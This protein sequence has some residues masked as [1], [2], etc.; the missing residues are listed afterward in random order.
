MRVIWNIIVCGMCLRACLSPCSVALSAE[1]E[2]PSFSVVGSWEVVSLKYNGDVRE[3]GDVYEFSSDGILEVTH[4]SGRAPSKMQ[5]TFVPTES[6]ARI[7][8]RGG[9][10]KLV[11]ICKMEGGN[12]VVCGRVVDIKSKDKGPGEFTSEKSSNHFLMRF[13]RR[14]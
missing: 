5:Y 4:A 2:A 14:N 12:L 7:E 11:G 6:P 13:S 1:P 9:E 10:F 8:W 3:T